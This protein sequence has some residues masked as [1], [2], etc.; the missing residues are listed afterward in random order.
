MESSY[1]GRKII[2]TILA[3]KW[4][5]L[6]L[7]LNNKIG[8]NFKKNDTRKI[9]LSTET[10]NHYK[11][12]PMYILVVLYLEAVTFCNTICVLAFKIRRENRSI[13]LVF[14]NNDQNIDLGCCFSQK[15]ILVSLSLFYYVILGKCIS[16]NLVCQLRCLHL[17]TKT[18]LNDLYHLGKFCSWDWIF[19]SQY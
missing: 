15:T 16:Y 17:K 13:F 4:N 6:W 10:A 12:I 1:I 18:N 9:L 8:W 14:I 7:W 3:W 11:F 2:L 5:N 19:N